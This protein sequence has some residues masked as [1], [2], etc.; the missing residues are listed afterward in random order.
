MLNVGDREL[1][2]APSEPKNTS[3]GSARRC[4]RRPQ[5]RATSRSRP[6]G[7]R[8]QS[9]FAGSEV[10]Q[11][12]L[13][14]PGRDVAIYVTLYDARGA[15]TLQHTTGFEVYDFWRQ[16]HP[17]IGRFVVHAHFIDGPLSRT[18]RGRRGCSRHLRVGARSK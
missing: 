15:D 1:F 13:L 7:R 8:Q 17:S 9:V 16:G 12:N 10:R 5:R 3:Q 14:G 2:D 6:S 11:H 18:G 4:E